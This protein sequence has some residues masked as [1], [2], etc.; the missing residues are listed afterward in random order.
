MNI[1]FKKLFLTACIVC[2]FTPGTFAQDWTSY[3]SH[4][5][6]TQFPKQPVADSQVVPTAI[7]DLTLHTYMYEPVQPDNNLAYGVML[8][9]YPDTFVKYTNDAFVKGF[10][11]GVVDGAAKNSGGKLLTEKEIEMD[12]YPG[13]EVRID[14]KEG[15]AVVKMRLYL[16]KNT[17]YMQQVIMEPAKENNNT[18]QKFFNAFKI[19]K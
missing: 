5:F 7:G 15:V 11:R 18:E 16:V 3:T 10:F 4:G 13:R 6:T 2:G 19:N 14:Y 8:T 9:S 1:S 12:G 17:I